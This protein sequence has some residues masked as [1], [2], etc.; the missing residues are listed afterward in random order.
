MAEAAI[1][2][3]L[4]SDKSTIFFGN[5]GTEPELLEYFLRPHVSSKDNAWSEPP[6]WF[7]YNDRNVFIWPEPAFGE[8]IP[9]KWKHLVFT[10][11]LDLEWDTHNTNVIPLHVGPLKPLSWTIDSHKPFEYLT[12]LNDPLQH[13]KHVTWCP[14]ISEPHEVYMLM[15]QLDKMM[16]AGKTWSVDLSKDLKQALNTHLG[17]SWDNYQRFVKDAS[18]HR[19]YWLPSPWN[20]KNTEHKLS[21]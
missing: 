2:D 18:L 21:T 13:T 20:N 15:F 11:H 1:L 7:M 12:D 17:R 10:T 6:R 9:R 4:N 8:T 16:P 3:A 5:L 14:T 19:M